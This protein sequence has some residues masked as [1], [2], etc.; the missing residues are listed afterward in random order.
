MPKRRAV[1]FDRDGVI[2]EMVDRGDDFVLGGKRVRL[3]APWRLSEL[4]I[5][6]HAAAAIAAVKERGYLAIL[7]TN[8]PDVVYGALTE[9]AYQE[10]H[11]EI[12]KLGFDDV[13][14]CRHG[15]DDGCSCRKPKPGLLLEAARKWSIDL[16]RSFFVGD[17]ET[18]MQAAKA[19]GC[20]GVLMRA[21]Y[22]TH[23]SGDYAIAHL[24]ELLP[25]VALA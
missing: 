14:A 17:M 15:R 7:A 19:A 2:N 8:Q 4:K 22:N 18:D 13:W 23:V 12:E 20:R 11:R 3:T 9:F 24:R 1:F 16:Q 21:P 6:A 10:I 25:L 5:R